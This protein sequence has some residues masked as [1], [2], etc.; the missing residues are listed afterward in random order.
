MYY[1]SSKTK[2]SSRE[3]TCKVLS[4]SSLIGHTTQ[5]DSFVYRLGSLLCQPNV[6]VDN[7]SQDIIA[8]KSNVSY[9]PTGTSYLSSG[10]LANTGY[11]AVVKAQFTPRVLLSS[12]GKE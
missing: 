4:V 2:Y 3:F 8:P 12:A 1:S 7:V 9:L 11:V 5:F 6:T 10:G